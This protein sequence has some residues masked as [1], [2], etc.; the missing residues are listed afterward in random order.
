MISLSVYCVVAFAFFIASTP[1]T[2][3]LPLYNAFM[4]SPY[5]LVFSE[6]LID[7]AEYSESLASPRPI[8]HAFVNP[9]PIFEMGTLIDRR[10][11]GSS[12]IALP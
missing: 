10:L 4:Y 5:D 1:S 8:D 3:D 12:T 7:T 2:F 11:N 9:L 6:P